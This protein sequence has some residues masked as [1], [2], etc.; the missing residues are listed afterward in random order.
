MQNIILLHNIMSSYIYLLKEREFIKTNENIYK[1]GK[2]KQNNENRIKQYPKG[3]KLFL[4]K[5]CYDCDKMEN[6]LLASF[7]KKFKQR[8]D[9]GREYFEGEY[10]DM[11]KNIENILNNFNIQNDNL[12]Q[13]MEN[14]NDNIFIFDT[15][16]KIINFSN[17]KK[18]VTTHKTKLNG[19]LKFQNTAWRKIKD[20]DDDNFNHS[21]DED[22]EGF[23]ENNLPFKYDFE[24]IKKDVL[25]NC[26][27]KKA[28]I[29]KLKYNEYVIGFSSSKK[30]Y[31]NLF[32]LMNFEIYDL[33]FDNDKIITNSR[34]YSLIYMNTDKNININI[35]NDIFMIFLNNNEHLIERFKSLCLNSL[36]KF[37]N[38]FVFIDILGGLSSYS[39]SSLFISILCTLSVDDYIITN[40]NN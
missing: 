2:T 19:F 13:D 9:I 34:K 26:Y 40:K 8:K 23:L 28:K 25:K 17:I 3:S 27:D 14:D 30:L 18:I 5:I 38:T 16:E 20:I 6:I 39:F 35:I 32:D 31:Y 10:N 21:Q 7:R 36:V 29:Y 22:L 33:P 37:K 4:L 15:Y 24:Q 11:I 12:N 1:L